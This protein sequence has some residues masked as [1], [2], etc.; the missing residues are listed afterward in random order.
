MSIS[1]HTL[2]IIIKLKGGAK[3]KLITGGKVIMNKFKLKENGKQ[4]IM[5]LLVIAAC[6]MLT[7]SFSSAATQAA[8]SD[9]NSGMQSVV[10]PVVELIN[11][12]LVPAMMLVGAVGTLYCIL[13]GVKFAKAEEQQERE[14]AKQHLKNAIIGF[15]LIFVLIVVL[16]LAMD[17]LSQ[18][19]QKSAGT[20][21]K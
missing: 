17:P 14:K 2:Y 11:S 15:V 21:L 16:N 3:N 9:I 18:W 12:L 20:K 4:I 8:A 5:S 6:F 10:K 13:L 19:V 1:C 7:T